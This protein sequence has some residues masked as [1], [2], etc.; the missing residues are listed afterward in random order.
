MTP[1]LPKN[2]SSKH[3]PYLASSS[4]L[5]TVPPSDL[6]DTMFPIEEEIDN[7]TGDDELDRGM[8]I[9]DETGDTRANR[10]SMDRHSRTRRNLQTVVDALH[11]VGWRLDHFL[12]AWIQDAPGGRDLTLTHRLYV[13]PDHRK[14]ALREAMTPT[15]LNSI[16][17]GPVLIPHGPNIAKEF[18]ALISTP[19]FGS[20]DH[21]ADLDAIDFDAAFQTVETAAPTWYRILVH[22]LSNSRASRD[23]YAF[24]PDLRK[25]IYVIT[26]MVCHSRAKKRS[27]QFP[28]M[29]DA[30]LIGSGV[31]RHVI[32]TLAGFGLCHGYKHGNR[33][34]AKVAQHEKV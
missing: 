28:S 33:L 26:S 2:V 31:K 22:V 14:K 12:N 30:Y 8:E 18:D 6:F 5:S 1:E 17:L 34:M 13:T 9:D 24:S 25:R 23:S 21:T 16:F 27:N 7:D 10:Q 29:L 19:Y 3:T 32:E 15:L 4:P 11:S 20:F